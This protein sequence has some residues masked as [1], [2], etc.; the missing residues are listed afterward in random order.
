MDAH[1][2]GYG[3]RYEEARRS[4]TNEQIE[5]IQAEI[6]GS[7]RFKMGKLRHI[8]LADTGTIVGFLGMNS[9]DICYPS[10][11]DP[12]NYEETHS[13]LKRSFRSV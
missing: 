7:G 3:G 2:I 1:T 10:G 5:Q 12:T 11:E 8:V 13:Q 4:L 6:F 9:V